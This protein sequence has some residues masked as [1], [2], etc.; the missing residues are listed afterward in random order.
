MYPFNSYP[1]IQSYVN[2]TCYFT[3]VTL[4]ARSSAAYAGN[5]AVR[6]K[7]RKSAIEW[8]CPHET[9]GRF[10]AGKRDKPTMSRL[11][12]GVDTSTPNVAR[13]YDYFLGGKDNFQ[14]DRTAAEEIMRLVPQ[15]RRGALANR[16]FLR[17]AVR[18]LAA[19]AGIDQFLDVGVGLPTQGAAHE[20]LREVRPE[21]RVA[22]VDYDPV[23]VSHARVLLAERDRS[24]AVRGDL[25]DPA[26]LLADPEI[27]GHLDLGRPVAVILLAILHFISD[28]D[29]PARI[30]ATVRDAI[31]PGSYL[32]V[33]HTVPGRV[34]DRDA[35][36][37]ALKIYDH[38]TEGIQPRTPAEI[39]RLLEG[40]ELLKPE[41][42]AG[43]ARLSD[44]NGAVSDNSISW[45]T[46]AR[47]P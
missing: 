39:A 21:A 15:I 20:V 29:D 44:A 2:A 45:R 40:F 10:A 18:Y 30:I 26:A 5:E 32:V 17:V 1:Q 14:A 23:V 38:A 47:K 13:M 3:S 25:R 34:L 27:R 19:E 6:R 31:A 16:A 24:I 7:S 37:R 41:V 28:D 42:M 36:D 8:T 12:D 33:S 11:L 46:L 43:Q 22:Y 9:V 4:T 35:A